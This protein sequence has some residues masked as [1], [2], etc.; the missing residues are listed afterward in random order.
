MN[1]AGEGKTVL[2]FTGDVMLGRLV[3]EIIHH[4]GPLYVWGDTLPLLKKAHLRLINLECVIAENGYQWDKTPKMFFFRADPPAIDV[5]K[6]A[7][8]DYV[9]LA[10]NHTL[11]FG[12]DAM[13]EMLNHLDKA[14]I[15]HAGAGRN[16][17]EASKPAVLEVGGMRVGVISFTDNEPPFAA[18]RTSAGTNYI[19]ITEGVLLKVRESVDEARS[20]SDIIVLSVHW[21]PNMIERPTRRFRDFA[22]AVIDMGVDIYHGHSAHIFQGVEIYKKKLIMYDTGDFIDDYYVGPGERNDKQLLFLVTIWQNKIERVE[23]IPVEISMCQ[24]NVARG[25]AYK[26]ISDIITGLS[27]EFGTEVKKRNGR[28]V[29]DVVDVDQ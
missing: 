18:T 26:E 21:G 3:N 13:I 2:A 7:G 24:V 4:M 29:I 25:D 28:L 22:H 1:A 27:A 9:S 10:N 11:D 15:V 12:E 20:L 5:L 6:V 17:H 23:M 14:G 8:I 16:L 19:P